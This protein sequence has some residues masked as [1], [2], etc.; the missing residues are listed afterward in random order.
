VGTVSL[1]LKSEAARRALDLLHTAM[2][3]IQ[4]W[5]EDLTIIEVMLNPAGRLW[6]DRLGWV[7]RGHWAASAV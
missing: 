3:P 7:C 1:P 5:L 6:T 4:D 2:G